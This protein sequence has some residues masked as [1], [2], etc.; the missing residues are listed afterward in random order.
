MKYVRKRKI[1]MFYLLTVLCEQQATVLLNLDTETIIFNSLGKIISKVL[2]GKQFERSNHLSLK[3]LC[4]FLKL[5]YF[6][7]NKIK[8]YIT[9]EK[10]CVQGLTNGSAS[11]VSKLQ[12]SQRFSKIPFST[13]KERPTI[14]A[15][16]SSPSEYTNLTLTCNTGQ[17][18]DGSDI[19]WKKNANFL[20]EKSKNLSF[21]GLSRVDEGKYSCRQKIGPWYHPVSKD[22]ILLCK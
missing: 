18:S 21:V 15:S 6:H 11:L 17:E 16:S 2:H 13:S 20:P 4:F 3:S 10:H 5:C 14:N 19:I 1:C 12:N 8:W 7:I 9:F 22:Y